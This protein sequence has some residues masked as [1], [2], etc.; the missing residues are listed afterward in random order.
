MSVNSL[1]SF[2]TAPKAKYSGANSLEYGSAH[3]AYT[4]MFWRIRLRLTRNTPRIF[5]RNPAR[6]SIFKF[7]TR[8]WFEVFD[9]SCALR[10]G[11]L[12]L[13]RRYSDHLWLEHFRILSVVR[14]FATGTRDARR[15]FWRERLRILVLQ[16]FFNFRESHAMNTKVMSH[17]LQPKMS[18]VV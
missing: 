14:E 11:R 1:A 13:H 8:K 18:C 12:M 4:A 16:V 3:A 2:L 7:N 9:K 17:F 6:F 10:F 5:Y 15:H